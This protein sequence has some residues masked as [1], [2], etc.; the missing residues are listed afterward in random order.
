MAGAGATVEVYAHTAWV[1][2]TKPVDALQVEIDFKCLADLAR[3][4]TAWAGSKGPAGPHR[5]GALAAPQAS[6]QSTA[7]QAPLQA[8]QPN[9]LAV[10]HEYAQ[11]HAVLAEVLIDGPAYSLPARCYTMWRRALR[12]L[13]R[14]RQRVLDEYLGL[15][16]VRPGRR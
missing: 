2:A 5:V 16:H 1:R 6:R 7:R 3:H 15:T 13:Y 11:E 8:V 12:L 10:E 4:A 14:A 9:T